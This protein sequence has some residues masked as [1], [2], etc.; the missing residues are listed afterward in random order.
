M[1]KRRAPSTLF[2]RAIRAC[3]GGLQ[4]LSPLLQQLATKWQA[5]DESSHGMTSE[6]YSLCCLMCKGIMN[7]VGQA[8]RPPSWHKTQTP[9]ITMCIASNPAENMC[10]RLSERMVLSCADRVTILH[11]NIWHGQWHKVSM[12]VVTGYM[13]IR[14][15]NNNAG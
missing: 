12:Y 4:L 8:F 10:R 14:Y 6:Q 15:H 1:P 11:N 3:R 13:L 7:D 9:N 2:L 5:N